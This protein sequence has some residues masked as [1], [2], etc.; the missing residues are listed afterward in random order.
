M[1]YL[2]ETYYGGGEWIFLTAWLG[3]VE[4]LAGD[5]QAAKER[6]AW[7]EAWVN[8]KG[9]LPEQVEDYLLAPDYL[10]RWQ[11]L[12]GKSAIPL[13]WSHPM[14]IILYKTMYVQ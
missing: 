3:W 5:A 4:S 9:W 10:Q 6:L 7:I 1:G 8:E 13:L 14:Y 12:W 2:K 11:V